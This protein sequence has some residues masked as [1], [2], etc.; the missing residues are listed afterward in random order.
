MAVQVDNEMAFFFHVNPYACDYSAASIR[1][2][3]SFLEEK[4]QSLATVRDVYRQHCK[5]FEEV[6]PPRR[7]EATTKQE[8][9]YYTDWIEYRERYLVD[10]MTR[11]AGMMKERGYPIFRC[12]TITR[13]L[14]APAELSVELQPRSICWNWKRSLILSASIFTRAKNYMT[15]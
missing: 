2:Y 12:S 10:S 15:M 11:L 1:R 4:Y 9:P 14:W 5:S 8:I 6:E 13:T 7:F 3:H